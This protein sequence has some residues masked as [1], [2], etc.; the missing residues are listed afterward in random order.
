MTGR[1]GRVVRNA[2]GRVGYELRGKGDDDV[3]SI[4]INECNKFM[5]GTKN[6]AIISDAA[7]TGISLHASR[8]CKNQKRRVHITLELPWVAGMS[9]LPD[10]CTL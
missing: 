7:S 2:G 1:K 8:Q 4:N 6:I 3:D 9:F 5:R 10:L